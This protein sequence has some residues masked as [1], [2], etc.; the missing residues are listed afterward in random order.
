MRFN[1]AF[2]GLNETHQVLFYADDVNILAGNLH[3]VKKNTEALVVAI[4]DTGLEVNGKKTKYMVMPREH[5]AGRNH[6]TQID[7]STFGRVKS[8]N[9]WEQI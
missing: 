3:N 9:N 5:N 7:N 8:S 4:M 1:S 6:N 2:K